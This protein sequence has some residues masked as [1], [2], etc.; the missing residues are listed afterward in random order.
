MGRTKLSCTYNQHTY[1]ISERCR[2]HRT[3]ELRKLT[4]ENFLSLNFK[5]LFSYTQN[6][7]VQ[8][9]ELYVIK[10]NYKKSFIDHASLV[11][12]RELSRVIFPLDPSS[13]E[14]F[15]QTPKSDHKIPIFKWHRS[16]NNACLKFRLK[17][18]LKK[19]HG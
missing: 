3:E 19:E 13:S 8:N 1:T 9:D 10:D 11:Y 18:N 17:D 16:V 6:E 4:Y 12:H 15:Y 7:N 5:S 2:I 14:L